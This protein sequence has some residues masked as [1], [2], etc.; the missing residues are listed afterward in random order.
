MKKIIFIIFLASSFLEADGYYRVGYTNVEDLSKGL[1][2]DYIY[3][4]PSKINLPMLAS[5]GGFVG[6][7]NNYNS[8]IDLSVKPFINLKSP[9]SINRLKFSGSYMYGKFDGKTD[10]GFGTGVGFDMI[11]I[12]VDFF[13]Y[14]MKDHNQN[15]FR[16]NFWSP[17]G[18]QKIF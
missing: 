4:L 17:I 15:V 5:V 13:K 16:L 6:D 11:F 1:S 9:L 10:Q 2:L 18:N 7:Q 3:D 14:H 8:N 12:S